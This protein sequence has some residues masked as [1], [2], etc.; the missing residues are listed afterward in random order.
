MYDDVQ[1][2]N[3]WN[4]GIL[5]GTLT[6]EVLNL[7][8][9]LSEKAIKEDIDYSW[10][11][12]G[13][14]YK[15][16]EVKIDLPLEIFKP[17]ILEYIKKF[18]SDCLPTLNKNNLL[19]ESSW[20]VSQY[21]GDYNPVHAHGS[22]FSGIIYLKVPNQIKQKLIYVPGPGGPH[23]KD[24]VDGC[25]QFIYGNMHQPTLQNFGPRLVVPKEGDFYIFPGYL[26]HTVY[27][28][29]GEGER[30]SLSFNVNISNLE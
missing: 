27:P 10:N 1:I 18:F 12:V 5:K 22:L 25:L 20:I 29:K 17:A 2:G 8:L 28:F 16:K 7:L 14:F 23:K 15:G 3:L 6:S 9:E 21:E 30:R 26:L 4:L 11:L 19:L 13:Q 24:C